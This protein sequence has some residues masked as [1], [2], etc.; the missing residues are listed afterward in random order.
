M[1]TAATVEHRDA[2]AGSVLAEAHLTTLVR[3]ADDD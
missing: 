3:H 1:T 2:S